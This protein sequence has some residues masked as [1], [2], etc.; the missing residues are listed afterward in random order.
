MLLIVLVVVG[1]VAYLGWRQSVPGVRATVTPPRAIGHKSTVPFVVQAARGQVARVEARVI[2]ND[3]SS[4]AL[5]QDGALGPRVE[6]PLAID[7]AALGLR[8]GT[9][10]LEIWGRDDFWRPLR[11]RD[12]MVASVPLT[13][14]LTPPRI[15][16]VASTQYLAPG[17]V[18][19]VVF[20][21]SDASRADV[22]VGAVPFPSFAAG[23]Q[24]VALIALP[25]D[26]VA[27]TPIKISAQDEA[28]NLAS[29][30][31]VAEILPRRFRRDRIEV[32]E[33]FL[34]L[35]V[36]ELLPQRPP[37]QPLIDGFLVINRDLRRQAEEAKRRIAAKTADKP[38]W[39]GAFVQPRN[40]KVFSNFAETRTYV[41]AGREIDTQVHLGFD[42]ASTKQAPVPAA[43]K[44]TVV[45]AG[46][47]T[48]YGNAVVLDHGWGL[49]TL[50]GH[51]STIGVK[52]GDSVDKEGELGRSG[53]TG[54]AVGDHLHYEVLVNGISV[55]PVEF[56]DAK[57]IRDRFNGPLKAAGLTVIAGVGE[58]SGDDATR[59][60][61]AR[62]RARARRGR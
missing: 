31:V 15:E 18:G 16:V 51:L 46:P 1:A 50:Y 7:A 40:T 32:R 41:Y 22:S 58:S 25:Y 36:P 53:D 44:G 38:L 23:A 52:V 54:L 43:N 28:G 37:S 24:R 5:T 14:D 6:I 47:L 62:P 8:E 26:Y 2:Q 33:A 21:A 60:A 29:R 13:L 27:G 12:R 55:T 57:W 48:I 35:K 19:V 11:Q 42:L 30:G 59:S 17:G 4:V 20:R 45:F 9:A 3:K 56:W 49:M 61:P 39:E 10:T 34:E